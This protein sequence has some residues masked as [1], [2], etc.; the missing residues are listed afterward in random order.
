[1]VKFS[2]NLQNKRILANV[3][4]RDNL[5]NDGD[6]DIGTSAVSFNNGYFE[7]LN[8]N[9]LTFGNIAFLNSTEAN[10]GNITAEEIF[11]INLNST[12]TITGNKITANLITSSNNELTNITNVNLISTNSSIN[13]LL[14]T[15]SS[16]TNLFAT[17]NSITN[18]ICTNGTIT[19]LR[20]FDLQATKITTT[21]LFALLSSIS[22]LQLI[23]GTMTNTITT[24]SSI[25][26]SRV[27][28]SIIDNG[29]V[30]NSSVQNCIMSNNFSFGATINNL[31]AT[32]ICTSNLN[33]T[34]L[35]S[36][37]IN[38]TNLTA[39]SA[40]LPYITNQTIAT[41]NINCQKIVG[42]NILV[43][44][45]TVSNFKVVNQIPNLNILN[46]TASNLNITNISS[47][48][49]N[50]NN[51]ITQDFSSGSLTVSGGSNLIG[52]VE[53]DINLLT[54][55]GQITIEA[56]IGSVALN[57]GAGSFAV[58]V[59]IGN[60]STNLGSGN[61]SF[62]LAGGNVQQD[63][64]AG[65]YSINMAVGSITNTIAAGAGNITN[66]IN[67]AGNIA[68]V[69]NGAGN[70]TNTINGAGIISNVITGAGSF[71]INVQAGGIGLTTIVGT[72]IDLFS[73]VGENSNTTLIGNNLLTAIG[74]K[75]I[76]GGLGIDINGGLGDINIDSVNINLGS[77]ITT[78]INAV[79][80]LINS[81]FCYITGETGVDKLFAN[82]LG[83]SGSISCANFSCANIADIFR[84]DAQ[85]ILAIDASLGNCSIAIGDIDQLYST[86]GEL[87][88]LFSTI[89]NISVGNLQTINATLGNIKNLNT[90]SGNVVFTNLCSGS[91]NAGFSLYSLLGNIE[92]LST[93][94]GN[95][96][97]VNATNGN[98]TTG[99]ITI[100]NTTSGNAKLTNL[101]VSNNIQT[102]YIGSS[103][104][105]IRDLNIFNNISNFAKIRYDD[106]LNFTISCAST[107]S[108][109][110]NALGINCTPGDDLTIISQPF[111]S[112]VINMSPSST[113]IFNGMYI[114][115]SETAGNVNSFGYNATSDFIELDTYRDF[116]IRS[117]SA[118]TT[119][120]LFKT[121]GNF[122]IQNGVGLSTTDPTILVETKGTGTRYGVM[123]INND[124]G[125]NDILLQFIGK[126]TNVKNGVFNWFKYVADG[127]NSNSL[128]WDYN[129]FNDILVLKADG[130]VGIGGISVPAYTLQLGDDS[131]AKLSTSTWTV[132]SDLRLKKDIKVHTESSLDIISSLSFKKFKYN[133]PDAKDIEYLGLLAQDIEKN[134]S[135]KNCISKS[136]YKKVKTNNKLRDSPE[137]QETIVEELDDAM[138][139]NY[140]EI[141]LHGLASIKELS[142]EIKE[143]KKKIK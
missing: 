129:G 96:K 83:V 112:C 22:N 94:S 56:R 8:V 126:N 140:H 53:D 67:G 19:N 84:L 127:S 105:E 128:R 103:T 18:L 44:N 12:F 119:R 75:V 24:N 87:K 73:G 33:L 59:G 86:S 28:D 37:N 32:N 38:C 121:S 61:M 99:N 89:G 58:D 25:S 63:L 74:G 69:I 39:S 132:W 108:F 120:F 43:D 11:T 47:T 21:N 114:Y 106:D 6:C 1:M 90:T 51:V 29:Y 4:V 107:I 125:A 31:R 71:G 131:A 92:I 10:L 93:T 104:A 124:M 123:N 3:Y 15:N 142:N 82:K 7:N 78:E 100:L 136:K 48:N 76:I 97:T 26:N 64:A 134:T 122:Q 113:G 79:N 85:E 135:L 95:L 9:N 70:M 30:L 141:F 80:T 81:L 101:T 17:N 133:D 57:V 34:G 110:S 65:T 13:S 62:N 50:T 5:Y 55:S 102:P 130:K 91:V 111:E 41:T 77:T 88:V 109:Y 46:L 45:I 20:S 40:Y 68:S 2:K 42:T 137:Y 138:G 49:I 36:T 115:F 98:F 143:L 23:N 118:G 116:K 66:V 117:L 35:S 72:G 52:Y 16:I 60:Y 139:L 14:A 54:N 27:I